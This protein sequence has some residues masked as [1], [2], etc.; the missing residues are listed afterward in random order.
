MGKSHPIT[1]LKVRSF[2]TNLKEGAVVRTGQPL[3]IKGIAF[4]SGAGIKTVEVSVDGGRSW[5]GTELGEDLGNFSF[6]GW[7]TNIVPAR[8]GDLAL[9]V[10]ATTRSGESQP[11]EAQW[12]PGGYLRNVVE[13]LKL[14]AA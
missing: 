4:D 14:V 5:R 6:R 1:K 9:M 8:K 10:R 3:E 11:L 12:N 2:V 7:R 13:T